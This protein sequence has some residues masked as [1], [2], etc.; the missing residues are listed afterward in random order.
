[1]TTDGPTLRR[2]RREAEVTVTALAR[3]LGVHRVT[4]HGWEGQVHVNED[5]A[6][7]YREAVQRL[8]GA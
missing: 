6:A 2:E 3:A 1:M 8:R 4:V 5:T 7:R